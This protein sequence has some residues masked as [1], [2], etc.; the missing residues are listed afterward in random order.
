MRECLRLLS[1]KNSLQRIP[2]PSCHRIVGSAPFHVQVAVA[3]VFQCRQY[4]H[5]F[6]FCA[7]LASI[8]TQFQVSSLLLA[9]SQIDQI[10]KPR[11]PGI[12]GMSLVRHLQS[13]TVSN[14]MGGAWCCYIQRVFRRLQFSQAPFLRV[15]LGRLCNSVKRLA[16]SSI[17]TADAEIM[18]ILSK[19]CEER[20]RD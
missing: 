14:R 8:G 7:R 10:V 12:V 18:A 15:I 4:L 1:Q 20:R 6:V 11:V 2:S 9:D 19:L 3:L 5:I 17:C 16:M 13:Q